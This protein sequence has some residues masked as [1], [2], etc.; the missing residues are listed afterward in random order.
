MK[1]HK[2]IL[3][4]CSFIIISCNGQ[5][6]KE[7]KSIEPRVFSEKIKA[8]QNAQIIDV[9]TPKEFDEQ[10][11]DNAINIS[12]NSNDFDSRVAQYDKS[13]PIFVYCLSGGRSAKAAIK[14]AELGFTEVYE[15]DGGILKWNAAGL[16]KPSGKAIGMTKADFEKLLVSDK[17]VLVNFYAEWCAP[18]KKMAPFITRMQNELANDVTIIRIDADANK[19][20]LSEL[21]I[22]GLPTL[23]LYDKKMLQ[24]KHEG[25]ISE[26]DLTKKL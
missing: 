4:V 8:T 21:K 23:L 5:S 7:S 12:W 6:R 3:I 2:I 24:W 10:H 19:T 20:L 16:S 14:L 17:K 22:D 9:R 13:K 25:F 11:L 18:C 15:M 1:C 26:E